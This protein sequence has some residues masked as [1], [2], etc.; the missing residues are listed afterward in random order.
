[1]QSKYRSFLLI[2][3][4]TTA[5][6]ALP[7]AVQAQ[8]RTAGGAVKA[9]QVPLRI[10]RM[11][12]L[13]DIQVKTPRYSVNASRGSS[14]SDKEWGRIEVEYDTAPGWLDQVT[15]TYHIL[16]DGKGADG[17]RA[18]SLYKTTISYR[19]VAKGA[20][21][22][23][24]FLKPAAIARYGKIVAIAVEI[25]AGGIAIEPDSIVDMQ[26]PKDWWKNKSIIDSDAVT[27]RDGYLVPRN[28]SPWALVNM[29]DYE[30][31]Q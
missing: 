31:I 17:T 25:N 12:K 4:L 14:R 22:S 19:D 1:M 27:A 13:R 11:P 10:R 16:A 5:I 8:T 29:D 9:S 2:S 21:K 6:L 15:F 30:D 18:F 26:L 3:C 28:R 23:S 24:V 7:A 20:H